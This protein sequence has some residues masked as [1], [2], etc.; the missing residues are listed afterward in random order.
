[1]ELSALFQGR[2][3]I[4][5]YS[6]KAHKGN[7]CYHRHILMGSKVLRNTLL[8]LN[9]LHLIGSYN[10]D[11]DVDGTYLCLTPNLS[12]LDKDTRTHRDVF[13]ATGYCIIIIPILQM[14]K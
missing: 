1:M 11:D 6:F 2:D 10:F 4:S 14:R 13:L 12:A 8:L 3:C 5:S 7:L 9:T